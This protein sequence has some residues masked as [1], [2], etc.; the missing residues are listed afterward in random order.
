MCVCQSHVKG[1]CLCLSKSRMRWHVPAEELSAFILCC[2][3]QP[4]RDWVCVS[5]AVINDGF[6]TR[7]VQCDDN[8][9]T[10]NVDFWITPKV[11]SWKR[12]TWQHL[13][14]TLPVKCRHPLSLSFFF[15]C[16]QRVSSHAFTAMTVIY[17][18]EDTTVVWQTFKGQLNCCF[19][20]FFVWQSW[21]LDHAAWIAAMF[22][23]R[24][25]IL[26]IM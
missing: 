20:I 23:H 14:S 25:Q 9:V 7:R 5:G 12:M 10:H 24:Q 19:S 22:I 4:H 3:P 16:D 2:F 26:D 11:P 8:G 21:I 13:G 1:K 18:E 6:A 17:T 15:H